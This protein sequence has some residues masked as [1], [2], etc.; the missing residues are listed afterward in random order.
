MA[1]F[2]FLVRGAPAAAHKIACYTPITMDK[3]VPKIKYAPRQN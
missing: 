2:L 1:H 3:T